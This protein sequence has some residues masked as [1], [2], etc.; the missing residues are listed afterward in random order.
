MASVDPAPPRQ[1]EPVSGSLG[2]WPVD[3]EKSQVYREENLQE[4][5]LSWTEE[6]E[7]RIR[8]K[9]DLFVMPLMTLIYRKSLQSPLCS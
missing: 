4:P 3:A 9:I 5:V 2:D 6:Q 7:T 8:R 1:Q